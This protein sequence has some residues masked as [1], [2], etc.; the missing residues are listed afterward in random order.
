M[1][2]AVTKVF[3]MHRKV[4]LSFTLPEIRTKRFCARETVFLYSVCRKRFAGSRIEVENLFQVEMT[5]APG[6][7]FG[8]VFGQ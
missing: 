8:I 6:K 2:N 1:F 7:P 3:P 5:A 4:V